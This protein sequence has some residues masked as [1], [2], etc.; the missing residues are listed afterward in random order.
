M[1]KVTLQLPQLTK[2]PVEDTPATT[3][4]KINLKDNTSATTTN[5]INLENNTPATT[6]NKTTSRR[7]TSYHNKQNKSRR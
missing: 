2:I 4:N 7:Y 6:T 5:R 1:L 3:T